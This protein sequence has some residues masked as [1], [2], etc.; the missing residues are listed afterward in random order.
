MKKSL[1]ILSALLIVL[2]TLTALPVYATSD[3]TAPYESEPTY[4]GTPAEDPEE[5]ADTT[6]PPASDGVAE[7]NASDETNG[8][9]EDVAT[10]PN[11]P[12][13]EE[14]I[15]ETEST[16]AEEEEDPK[17]DSPR[18]ELSKE[19][20][21][22]V[23]VVL[24]VAVVALALS[25]R[26]AK[27]ECRQLR[28]LI[29]ELEN[30]PAPAPVAPTSEPEDE[31]ITRT[32]RQ[33]PVKAPSAPPVFYTEGL[34]GYYAGQVI[35]V[36]NQMGFGRDAACDFRYPSEAGSISKVHCALIPAKD[37][38]ILVDLGSTCGTY[39]GTGERLKPH[40][41]YLLKRGD[42]FFLSNPDQSF[43]IR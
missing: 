43:R 24:L 34:S 9:V 13:A 31:M 35:P 36:K 33:A 27:A 14:S 38:V 29:T 18:F 20:L 32:S 8:E 5:V 41:N 6:A 23:S 25:L 17:K 1:R 3:S 2:F 39:L 26:S 40:H 28:E 4:A 7:G 19:V 30:K 11:T 10:D 12:A 21:M 16:Q 42:N 37:G 15:S 22:V